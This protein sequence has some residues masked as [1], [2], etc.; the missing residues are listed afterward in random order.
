MPHAQLGSS[1]SEKILA[2]A[3]DDDDDVKAAKILKSKLLHLRSEDVPS[4]VS[5]NLYLS[6]TDALDKE[7]EGN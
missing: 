5:T 1:D 2:L 4:V 3:P 6:H 7:L